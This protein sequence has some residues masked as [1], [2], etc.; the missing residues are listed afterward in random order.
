MKLNNST[1]HPDNCKRKMI[2]NLKTFKEK[3]KTNMKNLSKIVFN[4][5]NIII[6]IIYEIIKKY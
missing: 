4:L 3:A 6:K 2:N 5:Y 1:Q